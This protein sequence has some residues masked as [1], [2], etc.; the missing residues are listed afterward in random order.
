MGQKR[1]A[2]PQQQTAESSGSSS[3]SSSSSDSDQPVCA[4]EAACV[5]V[6]PP[7][8]GEECSSNGQGAR[9]EEPAD[10]EAMATSLDIDTPDPHDPDPGCAADAIADVDDIGNLAGPEDVPR[11]S[12]IHI[13]CVAQYGSNE[14]NKSCFLKLYIVGWRCT[15]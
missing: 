7:P 13:V 3:S 15:Q 6:Q 8:T 1:K 9:P 2:S 11:P 12:I 14:V 5:D 4:G 10:D